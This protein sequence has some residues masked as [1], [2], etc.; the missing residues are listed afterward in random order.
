MFRPALSTTPTT[1]PQTHSQPRTQRAHVQLRPYTH[2]PAHHLLHSLLNL[3]PSLAQCMHAGKKI[4]KKNDTTVLIFSA[5]SF[6]PPLLPLLRIYIVVVHAHNARLRHTTRT[7]IHTHPHERTPDEHTDE[8]ASRASFRA[9][10][11]TISR[12][13][14]ST[15]GTCTTMPSRNSKRALSHRLQSSQ[16]CKNKPSLHPHP[17]SAFSVSSSFSL[18]LPTTL[19]EKE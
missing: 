11:H 6:R 13:S 17:T 19:L 1:T 3:L 5:R 15:S 16:D 9:L 12:T 8:H 18:S 10:S 14:S 4:Q 2:T 7:R